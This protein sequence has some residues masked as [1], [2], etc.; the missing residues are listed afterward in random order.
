MAIEIVPYSETHTP[1]VVAFNRRLRDG[2]VRFQFPEEAVPRWLPPHQS[3]DILQQ[4][5]LAVD[6]S[7]AV[8]GG[9]ILKSQPFVVGDDIHTVGNYQLPL[10]EGTVDRAYGAVALA[11]LFNAL[12]RQPL[13]YCLGMGGLERPLPKMLKAV[14]WS[15]WL[16][17]FYYRVVRASRF[18]RNISFLRTWPARRVALDLLAVTGLG[19]VGIRLKQGPKPKPGKRLARYSL[20]EVPQFDDWVD[21]IWSEGLTDYRLAAVRDVACLRRLYPADDPRFLRLRIDRKDRPVGWVVGLAT[22]LENHKQF[23]NMRLGSIVDGFSRLGHEAACIQLAS[24]F[25]ERQEV[26]LVVSNQ[27]HPAWQTGLVAAGLKLGPSNFGLALSPALA[28]KVEAS[29]S[30]RPRYHFTRGDGDGPINL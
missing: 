22:S 8:R 24:A 27:M 20:Q 28:Q 16:V 30:S 26:D 13:L 6:D 11:M 25:L 1:E 5:F 10:T 4:M 21:D 12:K 15:E 7:G 2:S 17:P 18:L 9:Y 14:G 3:D 19:R 23:G 29:T